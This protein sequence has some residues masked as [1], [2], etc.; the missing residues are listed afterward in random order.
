MKKDEELAKAEVNNYIKNLEAIHLKEQHLPIEQRTPLDLSQE[1]ALEKLAKDLAACIWRNHMEKDGKLTDTE[2]KE[3]ILSESS[4][5]SKVKASS[6]A[7]EECEK[8]D[9]RAAQACISEQ[10]AKKTFHELH[11][12]S[13]DLKKEALFEDPDAWI[14]D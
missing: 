10:K 4:S 6:L 12:K 14:Q 7:F 5:D 9:R 3:G 8:L 1:G 2:V 11:E 13:P